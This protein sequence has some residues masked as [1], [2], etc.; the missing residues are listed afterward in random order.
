L[1]ST[2]PKAT[3]NRKRARDE[4]TFGGARTFVVERRYQVSPERAFAAWADREAKARWFV[5]SDASLE[6]DFRVGGRERSRGTAP[7][8]KA[9]SYEALYQD[10]VTAE[11][12][13]YTY[14]MRLEETRISVSLAT[15]EFRPVGDNGTRLVFTEQGAFL[16]GHEF[17]ARRAEGM[18]SLL[19]ALERRFKARAPRARRRGDAAARRPNKAPGRGP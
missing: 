14:D 18:G 1:A 9:Y 11:R 15:V 7:D 13:V 4:R 8:G 3:T 12:I 19:D 2:S 6:L 5:D 10:I 17:P 16:D